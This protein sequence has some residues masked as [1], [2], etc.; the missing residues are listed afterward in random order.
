V[1]VAVSW[2]A[3]AAGCSLDIAF[4]L[5]LA[6]PLN[7]DNSSNSNYI[8]RKLGWWRDGAPWREAEMAAW[9]AFLEAATG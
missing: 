1:G 4:L 7:I 5:P 8:P 3:C 2:V 9:L 6:L